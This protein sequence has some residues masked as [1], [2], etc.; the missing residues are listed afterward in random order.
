M[1]DALSVKLQEKTVGKVIRLDDGRIVFKFDDEYIDYPNRQ[2]LSQAFENEEGGVRTQTRAVS[3]GLVP[4]FF[5][6]LLPEGELRTYLARRAGVNERR[7]FELLELLGQDLPG[8]VVVLREELGGNVNT[9]TESSNKDST[10]EPLR[11]SLAGVQLKFSAVEN[12]SGGLTIPAQG[13]GGDWIVKLPSKHYER[14]PENEY[15][16]MSMAHQVGIAIPEM[17]LM[18]LADI[19]GLPTEVKDLEESDAFVLRRFDRESD[20]RIHIEDFAQA[21]GKWPSDKY[22]PSVNYTD[23]ATLINRVCTENETLEFSRRLMFNAIVGNGD[24]HLKN[25]SFIYPDGRKPKLSP[26]Y[27]YL[28]TTVYIKNDDAALVFG[29]TKKWQKLTLNDFAA[30]AEGAGVN[31]QTFVDVAVD[32]AIEFRDCWEENYTSLP[33]DAR[34][35]ESIEHQMTSCPAIRSSIR[36]SAT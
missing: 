1:R 34:L 24:M 30:V 19:G 17:R 12:A 35:K 32:T 3:A 8:A 25:W 18:P 23:L 6:N 22:T 15:S 9:Y 4:S 7:E 10:L 26:A 2:V 13:I 31:Q 16:V 36:R 21:T 5:S 33:I 27:D 29:S 14:V 28:C 11:F 20:R